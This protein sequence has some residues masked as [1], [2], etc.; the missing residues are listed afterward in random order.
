MLVDWIA[1]VK[2][3]WWIHLIKSTQCFA[4]SL[5]DILQATE[6]DCQETPCCCTKAFTASYDEA[7][8]VWCRNQLKYRRDPEVHLAD[9]LSRAYLPHEHHPGKADQE[10][11]RIHS[12][13][14]LSVSEPQIQEIHEETARSAILQS[15]KAV[16]MHGWTSLRENLPTELRHYFNIRDE[17][18][19]QDCVIFKGPKCI[20]P[21]SLR[22]EIKEKLH[23]SHTGIQG[24][25]KRAR[26]VVYWPN[27]N[28]ELEDFISKCET[29]NTFQA[30]HP[31]EPLICH[32]I[33]QRPWVKITCDIFAFNHRDY[34]CTVDYFSKLFRHRW[35]TQGKNKSCSDWKIEEMLCH[36]WNPRYIP[37]WQWSTVWLELILRV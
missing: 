27:I 20:N 28:K 13:N 34:L 36:P 12:V 31:K 25:L 11:A 2:F 19:A 33:T 4:V 3:L 29:C 21:T 23:R 26:E 15:L 14:D 22:P 30:A 6:D 17:L 10:V 18:A 8:A 9:T 16:I 24:C 35:A 37:Q 7:N 32:D 1:L 5:V